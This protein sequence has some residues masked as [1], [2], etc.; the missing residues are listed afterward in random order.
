MKIIFVISDPSPL[1]LMQ[2]PVRHRRVEIDLTPEQE[3]EI[4]L[5]KTRTLG[6]QDIREFISMI[7][8]EATP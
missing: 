8:D 4:D 2:E 6:G 3:A 5:Q 1:I 7:F